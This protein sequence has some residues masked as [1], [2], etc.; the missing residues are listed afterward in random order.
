MAKI[1]ITGANGFI[2]SH[3]VEYLLNQKQEDDEIVCMV[4]STS[5]LSA[6]KEL[7]VK[8]AI[9]DV[10]IP[11]TL[12]QPVKGAAYIYHLAGAVHDV[13][14]QIFIDTNVQGMQNILKATRK[15]APDLKRFIF[16]SSN[17]AGGPASSKDNPVT[18]D[19]EPI[20][21]TS[22]YGHSKNAAERKV[23]D[24]GDSIPWTIV[25]PVPVYGERDIGFRSTF[26]GINKRI[27]PRTGFRNRYT[28]MIYC[29]DLVEG[30]VAAAIS[31]N[32]I[33]QVY[34]LSENNYAV[35]DLVKKIAIGIGKKCG[36]PIPVPIFCFRFFSWFMLLLN[37][38]FR[39][40][41]IP[42]PDKVRELKQMY[43]I[44]STEKAKRDFGWEAK[45][46]MEEGARKTFKY[47]KQEARNLK[48][49]PYECK[50]I[51]WTMFVTLAILIGILIE[52]MAVYGGVY[53]FHPW[54]LIFFVIVLLWG[55]VFGSIAL[56]MRKCGVILQ[57][58]PGFFILFGAELLNNFYLHAWTFPDD[59]LFGITN[60]FVRAAVLG[61]ATGFVIPII[62][63]M[64]IRF[65]R[66]KLRIG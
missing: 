51:R 49:M 63:F 52:L 14:E 6:L 2:G 28:A 42:S 39:T 24:L 22:W 1:L 47:Y 56:G 44:C 20:A 53:K 32:T 35:K 57:Y 60:P 5:D 31:N 30:I 50:G 61:T 55:G 10:T 64:M 37:Y 11:E 3:L 36:L 4:R 43:W 27:H 65:F 8:I 62:N 29:P 46:S 66:L 23:K 9:G 40:T 12:E 26:Q 19:Q 45:T 58:L 59:S 34:F 25:R 16:V 21:L 17:S 33:G 7:D 54:W 48:I 15:Y 18:E 38:F 41:P 13:R